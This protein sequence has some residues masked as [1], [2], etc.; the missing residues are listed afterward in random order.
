M[1]SSCLRLAASCVVAPSAAMDGWV[2][3]CNTTTARPHEWLVTQ[4]GDD[5][6]PRRSPTTVRGCS[7]RASG[8]AHRAC[9]RVDRDA[10]RRAHPGL[11]GQM[12]GMGGYTE[13]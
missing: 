2:G 7:K 1:W 6:Y 13:P 11:S 3:C 12:W 5:D 8:L 10:R 9:R 4:E